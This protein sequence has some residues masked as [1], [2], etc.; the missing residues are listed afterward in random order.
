MARI[1]VA[2]LS[3]R[4]LAEAAQRDGH[5]VLAL[6]LFGDRDTRA[7]A[8]LGWAGIGESQALRI[9]AERLLTALRGAAAQGAEGWVCGSG[10]DGLPELLAQGQAILPLWG[11]TPASVAAARD[12]KRFFAALQGYGIAHPAVRYHR[13]EWPEGWLRKDAHACG[14]WHVRPAQVDDAEPPAPGQYWQCEMT[15]RPMSMTLLADGQRALV[16]GVNQQQTVAWHGHPH[17]FVGVAG[18]VALPGRI[19]TA[20]QGVA[21]RL[22]NHFDLHGL[23]GVD[24]LLQ[25]ADI[26]VLE[27]NPRPPASLSLYGRSGGLF[28]AHLAACQHGRLPLGADANALKGDGQAHALRYVLARR[29]LALTAPRLALLAA[30]PG[31]HDVPHDTVTLHAG[32]PVCTLSACGADAKNLAEQLQNASREL[33]NALESTA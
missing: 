8:S 17:V 10:F 23:C 28:D 11:A 21:D 12:P 32:D 7:A 1:A 9:D 31:V 3:A 4:A 15:G 2:A 26:L 24:F 18:P 13:P 5:E 6:D 16:L 20:L 30:W 33:L 19:G 25:G 22:A 29:T 27:L 14:G